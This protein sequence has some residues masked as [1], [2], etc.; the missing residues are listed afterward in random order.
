MAPNIY[1]H[2][3][4][5]SGGETSYNPYN[6]NF[7]GIA[8]HTVFH[9]GSILKHDSN[10]QARSPKAYAN[11][12]LSIPTGGCWYQYTKQAPTSNLFGIEGSELSSSGRIIYANWEGWF[13]GATYE[14]W[15]SK[16]G[17][18]PGYDDT[19]R[20]VRVGLPENDT[21]NCNKYGYNSNGNE[22]GFWYVRLSGGASRLDDCT[23]SPTNCRD[24]VGGVPG[25]DGALRVH[26]S[27]DPNIF[28]L[29]N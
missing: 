23:T 24:I 25:T 8:I 12:R 27:I 3:K 5:L 7:A 21:L 28:R 15:L 11:C 13:N 29:S 2:A 16:L 4:R 17:G 22:L 1:N 20:R 19:P 6:G 10:V 26:Y 14:H 9:D 18:M